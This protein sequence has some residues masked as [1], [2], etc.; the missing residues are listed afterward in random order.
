MCVH[1]AHPCANHSSRTW[2]MNKF[3]PSSRVSL[4]SWR[5]TWRSCESTSARASSPANSDV[6]RMSSF[7]VHQGNLI[8]VPFAAAAAAFSSVT[9]NIKRN[10]FLAR[11]ERRPVDCHFRRGG[12]ASVNWNAGDIHSLG[13]SHGSDRELTE[14]TYAC[15]LK[16]SHWI[17]QTYLN[18]R[19]KKKHLSLPRIYPAIP[20]RWSP[21]LKAPF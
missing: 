13:S 7:C 3:E 19:C 4:C 11:D 21:H 20:Q 5:T 15:Y 17:T 16:S 9:L 6:F 2:W 12:R 1:Y 8:K 14:N 10:R 18:L